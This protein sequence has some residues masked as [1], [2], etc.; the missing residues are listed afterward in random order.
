MGKLTHIFSKAV[1]L[2][3][4]HGNSSQASVLPSKR[5]LEEF[6]IR[7]MISS[8]SSD[9]RNVTTINL[10]IPEGPYFLSTTTGEVFQA[11]RLYSDVQGAF[12]EGLIADGDGNYSVLS[13]AIP[14]SFVP[15]DLLLCVN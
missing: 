1:F 14:V 5:E 2:D 13:A 8:R 9:A 7:H 4:A 12:T 15:S 11:F 3:V 6:G 10:D